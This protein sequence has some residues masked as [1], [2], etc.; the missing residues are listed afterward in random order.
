MRGLRGTC[1]CVCVFEEEEEKRKTEK[2]KR[3]KKKGG[4]GREGQ[5]LRLLCAPEGL[6]T[7]MFLHR[8][9]FELAAFDTRRPRR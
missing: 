6:A 2:K 9:C 4:G 5:S 8:P 1:V 7:P 3:A